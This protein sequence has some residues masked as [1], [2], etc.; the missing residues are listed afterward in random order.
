MCKLMDM[1]IVGYH[2]QQLYRNCNCTFSYTI[3]KIYLV[4]NACTMQIFPM[5]LGSKIYSYT[6]HY[7]NI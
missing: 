4:F 6:A 1:K 3:G 2:K 7:K 5:A